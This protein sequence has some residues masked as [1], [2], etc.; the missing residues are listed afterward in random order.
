MNNSDNPATAEVATPAAIVATQVIAPAV[1]AALEAA[2]FGQIAPTQ[3]LN[4]A[5]AESGLDYTV[6]CIQLCP[7]GEP[8]LDVEGFKGVR[9]TDTKK[10]FNVPTEAYELAQNQEVL[11][12]A[13]PVI[14]EA[15]GTY[16]RMGFFKSGASIFA[17]AQLPEALVLNEKLTLQQN[18]V[19]QSSHDGSASVTLRFLATGSDEITENLML[20]YNTERG[21]VSYR[22][23]RNVR[24]R[25]E[26]VAA[27]IVRK[28]HYFRKLKEDSVTLINSPM[29]DV[30]A[31]KFIDR[32]LEIEDVDLAKVSST[33]A[34][35]RDTILRLFREGHRY[36][37]SNTKYAMVLAIAQHRSLH[38]RTR[39]VGKDMTEAEARFA[40]VFSGASSLDIEWAWSALM[41]L[42]KDEAA[43]AA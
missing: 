28:N 16:T 15:K 11:E 5:I 26:E 25:M 17:F 23:T 7:K 38:A 13:S 24:M 4:S 14:E 10:V 31:Q 2:P 32:L 1:E 12:F 6:E 37:V 39:K 19:V 33:K 27:L 42:V 41:K 36:D 18:I 20:P 9:R 3:D 34:E 8:E 43:V 30:S 22:H 29:N 40:S 35:A 21:R